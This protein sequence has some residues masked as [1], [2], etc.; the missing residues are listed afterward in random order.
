LKRRD[1]SRLYLVV[2]GSVAVFYSGIPA[3]QE[4]MASRVALSRRRKETVDPEIIEVAVLGCED[5]LRLCGERDAVPVARSTADNHQLANQ[6]RALQ[7]GILRNH[8]VNREAQ[9]IDLVKAQR[10]KGL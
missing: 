9:D 5:G 7:R 10:I 3:L 4:C 6:I 8:R 1:L 2:D